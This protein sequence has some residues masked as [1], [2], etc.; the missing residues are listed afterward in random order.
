MVFSEFVKFLSL[1]NP[2]QLCSDHFS[3][4]LCEPGGINM[5]PTLWLNGARPSPKYVFKNNMS[6]SN[7]KI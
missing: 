5:D 7:S 6:L 1:S 3:D 4:R 2:L